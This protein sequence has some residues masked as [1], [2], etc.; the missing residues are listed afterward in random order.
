M[1]DIIDLASGIVIAT[2][3]TFEMAINYAYLERIDL[4]DKLVQAT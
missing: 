1:T 4:R 2:F 3:E